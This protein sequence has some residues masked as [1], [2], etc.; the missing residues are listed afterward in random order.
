[1]EFVDFVEERNKHLDEILAEVIGEIMEVYCIIPDYEIVSPIHEKVSGI[2]SQEFIETRIPNFIQNEETGIETPCYLIHKCKKCLYDKNMVAVCNEWKDPLD[3]Y[4]RELSG[5]REFEIPESLKE[6][7]RDSIRA[8]LIENVFGNIPDCPD[9][10]NSRALVEIYTVDEKDPE[11]N[12]YIRFIRLY[13]AED[14][15][16]ANPIKIE[17]FE[18]GLT[19]RLNDAH[20]QMLKEGFFAPFVEL[21]QIDPGKI[22]FVDGLSVSETEERFSSRYWNRMKRKNF[23]RAMLRIRD[24][25]YY[26]F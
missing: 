11:T 16:A 14:P 3:R 18:P 17:S 7:I 20:D 5:N 4:I 1:M 13:W 6:K 12:Q 25:I 24:G 8:F 21:E 15:D 9:E 2:F 23:I 26:I 22:T 19:M 10:R